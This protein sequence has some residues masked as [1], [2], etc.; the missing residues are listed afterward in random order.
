MSDHDVGVVWQ[1][2]WQLCPRCNGQGH[3]W[4]PPW[5]PGDQLTW[6]ST[7]TESYQCRP[8]DGTGLVRGE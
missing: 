7:C 5:L 8:C 4:T 1:V 2:V 6:T 3:T